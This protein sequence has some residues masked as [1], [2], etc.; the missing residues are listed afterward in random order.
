MAERANEFMNKWGQLLI[1]AV[2]LSILVPWGWKITES[3]NRLSADMQETHLWQSS[4]VAKSE[5]ESRALKLEIIAELQNVVK[6]AIERSEAK[7]DR[8]S[9]DVRETDR[10]M[11]D[12]AARIGVVA[13]G[14]TTLTA[15]LGKLKASVVTALSDMDFRRNEP[16]QKGK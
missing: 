14:V 9:Q 12:T 5:V 7:Q 15:E 6:N 11:R 1:Q 8:L 3:M 4:H 13:D 16:Q 2:F 10:V